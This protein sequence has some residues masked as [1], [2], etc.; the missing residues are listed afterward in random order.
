[1]ASDMDEFLDSPLEVLDTTFNTTAISV[2][3]PHAIIF[4]DNIDE[5][6][7]D[8]YGPAIETHEVFPEKINVHFVE[9]ISKNEGKMLTWERGAGVTLACGTG[10]T[11]TAISGFKLGLFDSEVLLHLPGGDLKFNVY[12]KKEELGAFMEGP[13]QLVFDGEIQ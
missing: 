2:G 6:D 1:M 12:E 4:V 7:I 13:A 5:I 11:S 8:K 9:V 10:A 3:N